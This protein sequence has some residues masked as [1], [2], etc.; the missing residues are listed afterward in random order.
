VPE[1]KYEYKNDG[2]DRQNHVQK[3]KGKKAGRQVMVRNETPQTEVTLR[4]LA[5]SLTPFG[6][7]TAA[8]VAGFLRGCF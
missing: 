7:S 3:S 5:H 4:F 6:R 8:S 1:R 2:N